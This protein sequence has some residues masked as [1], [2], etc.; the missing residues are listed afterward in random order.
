MVDE[1]TIR[2][3]EGEL[4]EREKELVEGNRLRLKNDDQIAQLREAIDQERRKSMVD[5]RKVGEL[6]KAL[7]NKVK[8]ANQMEGR[9]AELV[10]KEQDDLETINLLKEEI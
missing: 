1:A 2:K 4:K 10:N 7:D 3:L 8:L 6:Q 9:M 5:E